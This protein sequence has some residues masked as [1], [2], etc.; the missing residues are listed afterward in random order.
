[1]TNV[2]HR[3][4]LETGDVRVVVQSPLSAQAPSACALIFGQPTD[5]CLVRIHSRCLYGDVFGSTECDCGPQLQQS[6]KLI[7]RESAGLVIY[8]DQEG[9][10]AGLFAKARAY[11]YCEDSDVDTFAAYAAMH[12]P[13]DSRSYDDAAALILQQH[14]QRVRLLTNNPDKVAG[15]EKRGIRVDR[16]PLRVPVSEAAERYLESK[17]LHGHLLTPVGGIPTVWPTPAILEPESSHA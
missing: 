16:E 7:R 3:L 6:I 1:M 15:L 2:E 5:G 17:R 12:L 13:P 9:R 8:L 4:G 14:I 11:R 10:G